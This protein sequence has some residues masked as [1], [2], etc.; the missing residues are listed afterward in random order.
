MLQVQFY[1][2]DVL[3]WRSWG[4]FPP[5]AFEL[6][7]KMVL[8]SGRIVS[9]APCTRTSA[10][11]LKPV[12]SDGYKEWVRTYDG[13][14]LLVGVESLLPEPDNCHATTSLGMMILK[15]RMT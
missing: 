1:K 5:K 12:P 11:A 4:V 9:F 6:G 15:G 10:P 13:T 2:R 7:M 14:E 3:I 8:P